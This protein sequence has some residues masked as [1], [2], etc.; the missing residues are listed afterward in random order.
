[1]LVACRLRLHEFHDF[2]LKLLRRLVSLREDDG[3]LDCLPAV[4]VRDSRDRAFE[5]GGML[6]EDAL[7]LERADPVSG[8]LYEVVR[9]PDEPDVSVLVVFCRVAGVVQAVLER[10]RRKLLVV[11]VARE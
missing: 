2:L 3:R 1:M 7:N 9:A 11:V 5:D 8:R 6:L 4:L 10:V